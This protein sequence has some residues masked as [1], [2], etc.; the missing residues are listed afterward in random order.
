MSRFVGLLGLL[1]LY[2][3]FKLFG[4]KAEILHNNSIRECWLMVFF[5]SGGNVFSDL[6][7]MTK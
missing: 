1:F 6:L 4:A 3:N 5:C 7:I 2:K